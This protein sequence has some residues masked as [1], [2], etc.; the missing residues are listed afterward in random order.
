MLCERALRRLI[1]M[2]HAAWGTDCEGDLSEEH[3]LA[4]V[5]GLNVGRQF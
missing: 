4:A 1:A 2:G 5:R 3:V